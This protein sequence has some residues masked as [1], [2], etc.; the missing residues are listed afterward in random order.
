MTLPA[1]LRTSAAHVF[2]D[3]VRHPVADERDVHHL[4]RVLRLRDGETVTV[5]DG[6]GAWAAGR[7]WS[8]RIDVDGPVEHVAEPWPVTI[9]AAIPKGD[10]LEWMVQKLTEVGVAA[11]VLVDCARSV[12]RW[13]A[14]RAAGHRDR[15][16]RIVREAAMQSRRVWLPDLRGPVAL[17]TLVAGSGV[18]LADPD[19]RALHSLTPRPTTVVVG[20]EGGLSPEERASAPT[21]SLG[22]HV[23]RVETAAVVAAVLVLTSGDVG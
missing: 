21:V 15:L 8:G 22:D 20:P 10:R 12:V 6:R 23:L 1:A 18:A 16:A 19:G 17:A 5:A 3:D 9:A 13:D 11:I 2:V 7:W 14:E 4:R